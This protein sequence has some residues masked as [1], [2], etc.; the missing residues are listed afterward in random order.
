VLVL[1]LLQLRGA[2][3]GFVVELLVD[4]AA[5]RAGRAL[6]RSAA[7]YTRA[8]GGVALS[9]LLPA[10]GP[11]RDALRR[12]GFVRVPEPL[13]PQVIRLSARGFGRHAGSAALADPSAWLLSWADTD[14]V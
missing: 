11:V 6:L 14:V 5:P 3:L 7:R 10:G 4:P 9:A 1:R 12:A 13:H 2:R 8:A